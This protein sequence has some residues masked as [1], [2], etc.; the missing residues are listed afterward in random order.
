MS[1]DSEPLTIIEQA[2]PALSHRGLL[3]KMAVVVI[4]GALVGFV[5]LSA[6]A[7]FGV[8]IG[9]VLAYANYFWQKRSIEAIFDQAR[10]GQRS[11]FLS[12]RYILRYVGL[13]A[14]VGIIYLTQMVS[15]F[16][17]VFGLAS[18]AIAVVVEGFT[19]I[20]SGS[21]RQES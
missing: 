1:E 3:I 5:F 2:P 15:M 10:E 13:G 12:A 9:G 19:S 16:A 18:F 6:K 20:F 14:A 4:A 21:N 8:L 17:V 7:G 11:R